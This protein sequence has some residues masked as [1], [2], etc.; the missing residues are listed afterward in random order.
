MKVKELVK[1]RSY[2][3]NSREFDFDGDRGFIDE[4]TTP[5]VGCDNID[6][7]NTTMFPVEDTNL[8]DDEISEVLSYLLKLQDEHFGTTLPLADELCQ[9]FVWNIPREVYTLFKD[10]LD[11]DIPDVLNI[12]TLFYAFCM[13]DTTR[14]GMRTF[15]DKIHSMIHE[16]DETYYDD[17]DEIDND[18]VSTD[19]DILNNSIC[20][21]D[22]LVESI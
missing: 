12:L 3:L 11:Y 5:T 20:D 19:D 13:R 8:N 16:E 14:S 2:T 18:I 1:Y 6:Y 4:K 10:S 15:I 17:N 7:G 9:K 21:D 22:C